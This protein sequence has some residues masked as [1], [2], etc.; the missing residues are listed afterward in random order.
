M[1][2]MIG[3]PSQPMNTS[4]PAVMSVMTAIIARTIRSNLRRLRGFDQMLASLSSCGLYRNPAA[5]RMPWAGKNSALKYSW[6][7]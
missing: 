4:V 3:I 6:L 1:K 2:L 5:S 7:S